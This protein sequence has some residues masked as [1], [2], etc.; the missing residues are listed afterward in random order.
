MGTR[1]KTGGLLDGPRYPVGQFPCPRLPEIIPQTPFAATGVVAGGGGCA[2]SRGV[3]RFGAAGSKFPELRLAGRG[4][5]AGL[6]ISLEPC[7]FCLAGIVTGAGSDSLFFRPTYSRGGAGPRGR[8]R[9]QPSAAAEF[10]F[11]FADVGIR[12]RGRADNAHGH[13]SVGAVNQR[14][15]FLSRQSGDGRSCE[16]LSI[17]REFASFAGLCVD[18]FCSGN[19]VAIDSVLLAA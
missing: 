2:V 12:A 13:G 1:I 16:S 14:R 6:A 7:I 9:Y 15:G 11:D 3:A 19:G 4:L 10:H 5:A 8:R 17:R 18:G